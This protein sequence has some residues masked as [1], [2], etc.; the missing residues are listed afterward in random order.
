VKSLLISVALLSLHCSP[1]WAQS[2]QRIFS[3]ANES[4][5]QGDFTSAAKHYEKIVEAGVRDADVYFN[6]ATTYARL[7][8]YGKA[9]LFFE[10]SLRIEPGNDAAEAGLTACR[11]LLGKREADKA[12]EAVVQTR[13]PLSDA[14]VRPFSENLLA[15]LVLLFDLAFFLLLI[16]LRVLQREAW[17]I[18]LGVATSLLGFL[19][20][21]TSGG[22]I[23]K[24]EIL[25]QGQAAIVL[26]DDAWIREGPDPRAQT[27]GKAQQGQSARILERE[28]D[29]VRVR[30]S[31]GS[32]GWMKRSDV[33]AI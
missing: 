4:Y 27:R 8:E 32:E 26:K 31:G 5:F 16:A 1:V 3:S 15:W 22:L 14:L 9:I 30:L 24:S 25:K 6:L 2:L 13:P 12:G 19:L 29:Y 23:V 7:G 18:G 28:T 20:V 10:R 33:E 11:N 17:R 21:I